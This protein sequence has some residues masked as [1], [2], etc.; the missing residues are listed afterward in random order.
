MP[1]RIGRHVLI[2][3]GVHS[4]TNVDLA[5]RARSEVVIALAPLV[6]DPA[7]PISRRRAAG[8]GALNAQL[9]R[10]MRIVSRAGG[11]TLLLRP[12]GDDLAARRGGHLFSQRHA[13]TIA[14]RAY[15]TTV[16]QL[17]SS[18]AQ[19]LISTAQRLLAEPAPPAS[20]PSPIAGWPGRP[21]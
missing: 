1:E 15:A 5:A 9:K 10:E 11:R 7:Y 21:R 8:R 19:D 17:K 6:Y 3:G 13:A 14:E 20:Y 16:E 2:D 18:Y 4:P 12:S